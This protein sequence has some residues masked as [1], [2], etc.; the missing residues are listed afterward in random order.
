MQRG[1]LDRVGARRR[2]A[3]TAQSSGYRPCRYALDTIAPRSRFWSSL[4][5]TGILPPGQ[6]TNNVGSLPATYQ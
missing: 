6:N 3:G 4:I 2:D 5:M 1:H